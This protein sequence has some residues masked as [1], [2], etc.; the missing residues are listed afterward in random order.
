LSGKARMSSHTSAYAQLF[1]K[2]METHPRRIYNMCLISPV[3]VGLSEAI[4]ITPESRAIRTLLPVAPTG[5]AI[6]LRSAGFGNRDRFHSGGTIGLHRAA[7]FHRIGGRII[8]HRGCR[9]WQHNVALSG[10]IPLQPALHKVFES[11]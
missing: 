6:R 1:F 7:G 9:Q 5:V 11:L 10:S 4:R 3:K 8:L 2:V